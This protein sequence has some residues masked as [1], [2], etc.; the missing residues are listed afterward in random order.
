MLSL[1][2]EH[3][4]S[5][6]P[7]H[8]DAFPRGRSSLCPKMWSWGRGWVV[9]RAVMYNPECAQLGSEEIGATTNEICRKREEK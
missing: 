3:D 5:A 9:A 4:D 2:L 6:S 8:S 1:L 7:G